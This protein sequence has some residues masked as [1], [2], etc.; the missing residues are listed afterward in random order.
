MLLAFHHSGS[1]IQSAGP[2]PKVLI[3]FLYTECQSPGPYKVEPGFKIKSLA[4][5]DSTTGNRMDQEI[6]TNPV[7][8]EEVRKLVE[9]SVGSFPNYSAPEFSPFATREEFLHQDLAWG[10][11][12]VAAGKLLILRQATSGTSYGRPGNPFHQGIVIDK[13]ELVNYI[14][15]AAER[16][17]ILNIRPVDL[18]LWPSWLL[19]RGEEELE[20]S[21]LDQVTEPLAATDLFAYQHRIE[22]SVLNPDVTLLAQ[23]ESSLFAGKNPFSEL[24][25]TSTA[26][27]GLIAGSHMLPASACWSNDYRILQSTVAK[28]NG[29]LTS[30]LWSN[31]LYAVVE[32]DLYQEVEEVIYGFLGKLLFAKDDY[33]SWLWQLPL[34]VVLSSGLETKLEFDLATLEAACAEFSPF[35]HS[36]MWSDEILKSNCASAIRSTG[37]IS[38]STKNLLIAAIQSQQLRN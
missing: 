3:S 23:I 6:A 24:H 7:L 12:E 14:K 34:A 15:S 19:V 25:L 36:V 2:P 11:Y 4:A 21:T 28:E 26:L 10:I 8:S 29:P 38:E 20:K 1:A 17:G 35:A 9:H 18:L 31:L 33:K 16:F 5:W 32:A 27:G 13:S 22:E 37:A 30:N